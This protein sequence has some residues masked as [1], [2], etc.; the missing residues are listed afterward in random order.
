MIHVCS[1]APSNGFTTLPLLLSG[2][3]LSGIEFFDGEFESDATDTTL[4][5]LRSLEI[6][7]CRYIYIFFFAGLETETVSFW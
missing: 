5:D 1:D 7:F 2:C 3:D 6:G 4:T